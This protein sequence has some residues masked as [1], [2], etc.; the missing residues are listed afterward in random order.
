MSSYNTI[1]MGRGGGES[2]GRGD[3]FLLLLNYMAISH[4]CQ[5]LNFVLNSEFPQLFDLDSPI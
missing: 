4:V 1:R 3:L 2:R 5:V